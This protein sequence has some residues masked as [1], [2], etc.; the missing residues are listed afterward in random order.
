MTARTVPRT[1]GTD[2]A[3]GRTGPPVPVLMYHSIDT[4]ASPAFGR[5]VLSPRDLRAHLDHLVD[6]GFTTL[7]AAALAGARRRGDA[8]PHR[9]VVLTF[10]DAYRDF[11]V[12]ALPELVRRGLTATLFVPT[13]FVGATARWLRGC[14]EQ[15][16]PLL[17]WPELRAVAEAGVE[18][19]AHSH[20][21]PQLDRLP[22]TRVRAEAATSRVALEDALGTSV[23][24]FA[25]PYGYWDRSARQA[26]RAAGFGYACQVGELTSSATDDPW[27]L[28]R[29]SIDAGTGVPGLTRLL[30]ASTTGRAA[31]ARAALGRVGW[32]T[33]RRIPGVGGN[34]REGSP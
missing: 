30:G 29:H 15:D 17:G 2:A 5:Y 28:P 1:A 6:H 4:H 16:R 21:H 19:A 9:P 11:L 18:V 20:T 22:A 26:V 24:G 14:G 23:D 10:D 33:A 3:R 13:A 32:R 31:H 12:A 34:P 7:T 25:Y 27:S 8:L